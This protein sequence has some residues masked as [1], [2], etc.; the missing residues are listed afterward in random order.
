MSTADTESVSRSVYKIV[1]TCKQLFRPC[2]HNNSSQHKKMTNFCCGPAVCL[3][4][5][6]NIWNRPWTLMSLK[7][8]LYS[9]HVSCQHALPVKAMTSQPYFEHIFR[10]THGCEKN[11]KDITELCKHYI[12]EFIF[13][14][15]HCYIVDN[16]DNLGDFQY[17]VGVL[18]LLQDVTKWT[19]GCAHTQAHTLLSLC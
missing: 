18:Q 17:F 16:K 6:I 5:N 7:R 12:H 10:A 14:C 15:C 2:L 4:E 11:N 13:C 1:D 9:R 19:K 3:H 8:R